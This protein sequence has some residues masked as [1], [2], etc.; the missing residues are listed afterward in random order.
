MSVGPNEWVQ[1]TSFC[2]PRNI[3]S[4]TPPR[5]ETVSVS[6]GISSTTSSCRSTRDD[7]LDRIFC[8]TLW[9]D[10]GRQ[11]QILDRY[12]VSIEHFGYHAATL[13][14]ESRLDG[15]FCVRYILSIDN[16]DD[17]NNNN[18]NDDTYTVI[19]RLTLWF[20]SGFPL[21]WF[22]KNMYQRRIMIEMTDTCNL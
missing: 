8:I 20:Y 15:Y 13:R 14:H 22:Q 3:C 9:L 2:C 6:E 16:D 21:C 18:N 17:D 1:R 12:V 7:S 10:F 5:S 11:Y 4:Q 19:K